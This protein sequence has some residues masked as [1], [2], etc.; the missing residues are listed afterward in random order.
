MQLDISSEFDTKVGQR[1]LVWKKLLDLVMVADT[2]EA[3]L[4]HH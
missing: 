3:G 2:S 1:D 4:D